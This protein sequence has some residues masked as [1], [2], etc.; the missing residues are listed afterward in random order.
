MS[1]LDEQNTAAPNFRVCILYLSQFEQNNAPFQVPKFHLSFLKFYPTSA[2]RFLENPAPKRAPPNVGA[3]ATRTNHTFPKEFFTALPTDFLTLHMTTSPGG[4]GAEETKRSHVFIT[5]VLDFF[6]FGFHNNNLSACQLC[7]TVWPHR[8]PRSPQGPGGGFAAGRG[9]GAPGGM[10]GA[11][12]RP[13]PPLRGDRA[14]P[15]RPMSYVLC[16]ATEERGWGVC[17]SLEKLE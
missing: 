2:R 11:L 3:R 7:P 17:A 9:S 1:I 15:P 12:G 14:P 4:G 8:G 16:P 10:G 6:T 13:V 5:S